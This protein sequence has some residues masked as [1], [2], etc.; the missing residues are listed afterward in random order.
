MAIANRAASIQHPSIILFHAF[1]MVDYKVTQMF[2][3]VGWE[4]QQKQWESHS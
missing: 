1:V 3:E 4:Q 2:S